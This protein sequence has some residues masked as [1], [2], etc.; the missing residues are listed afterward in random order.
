MVVYECSNKNK[1]ILHTVKFSLNL[2]VYFCNSGIL[3]SGALC[4]GSLQVKGR[5]SHTSKSKKEQ[6]IN[7]T[8][9]VVHGEFDTHRLCLKQKVA[10]CCLADVTDRCLRRQNFQLKASTSKDVSFERPFRIACRVTKPK[11]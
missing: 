9:C 1:F 11:S 8:L 4:Q 2:I 5:V 10:P 7:A 3:G 6:V